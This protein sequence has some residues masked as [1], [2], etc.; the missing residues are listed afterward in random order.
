MARVRA[1]AL[2]EI[3]EDL[4]AAVLRHAGAGVADRESQAAVLEHAQTD[5]DA[6]ARR[7]LDGV[8]GEI[9][10]RLAQPQTVADRQVGRVGGDRGGD[11]E[12]LALRVR[13]QQFDDLFDEAAG[14]RTA[15]R[16][17][18]AG[19]PRSSRN[20]GSGRRGGRARRR[21]RGSPRRSWPA[22]ARARRRRS[23]SAMPTMPCSGVRISWL[24]VARKR[25]LASLAASA[26]SRSAPASFSRHTSSRSASLLVLGAMGALLPAPPAANQLDDHREREREKGA[27][28]QQPACAFREATRTRGNSN[29]DDN[30][31]PAGEPVRHIQPLQLR[32]AFASS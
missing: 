16:S 4:G 26:R 32:N 22:Q 28:L 21:K 12:A 18:R 25:D 2:F 17:V 5:A 27:R 30:P 23:R 8:A 31:K 1:V 20:R 14:D 9:G 29:I 3:L 19:R 24:I 11:L 15:P 10:Q 7:E 13:G 6:A